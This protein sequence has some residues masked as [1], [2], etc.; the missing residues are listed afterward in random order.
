MTFIDGDYDWIGGVLSEAR[1]ASYLLSAVA[2]PPPPGACTLNISISMAFY[3]LLHFVE[4]TLRNAL[5]A[6]WVPVSDV[7]T[8]G[9]WHRWAGMGSA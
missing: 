7:S 1:F 8:G 6:S 3:P 9:R 2:T 5:I 4:I